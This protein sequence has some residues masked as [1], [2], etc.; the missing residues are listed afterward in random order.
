MTGTWFAPVGAGREPIEMIR[1]PET[2]LPPSPQDRKILVLAPQPFYED[3][4]TPI[5]VLE[6]VEA[7]IEL[8]YHVDVATFPVGTGVSRP[9]LTIHRTANPFRF[10]H[11]PIGF[12]LRKVVL[13]AFL[14]FTGRRLLKSNRYVCIHAVEEAGF[15]GVLLSRKFR[16][17]V[18]YDMQSSLPD[19]LTKM[20]VFRPRFVQRVLRACERWLLARA[21]LVVTSAGLGDRAKSD[22]PAATIQEWCFPARATATDP[23]EVDALRIELAIRPGA[24]V[25]LYTGTFESYQGLDE[26]V[27]AIPSVLATAPETV[28]VLVGGDP[29]TEPAILRRAAKLGVSGALRIVRRQPRERMPAYL[30]L[31]DVLISPRARGRNFPIKLFHYLAAGRAVIASGLEPH[32][33]LAGDHALVIEH[34]PG[35]LAEAILRVLADPQLAARLAERAL[36]FAETELTPANFLRSVRGLCDD[37]EQ[38]RALL[39]EAKS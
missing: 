12:S 35:A 18:I 2:A 9:G 4:G 27:A 1:E 14:Y 37:A 3:R 23:S 13:D 19:E 28:F 20:R 25:V 21:D 39:L 6:L 29:E 26:L 33:L 16:T 10:R 38:R 15:L 22:V 34:T 36:A 8:G 24:P 30:A 11:V 17:P 5:A 7:L 31:A 32:R